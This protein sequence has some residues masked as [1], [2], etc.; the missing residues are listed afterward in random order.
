M[1]PS[2]V[3]SIGRRNLSDYQRYVLALSTKPII[4]E[5]E[6]ARQQDGQGGVLLNP[7]SDEATSNIFTVDARPITSPVEPTT[8]IRTDTAVASPARNR[9]VDNKVTAKVAWA[10]RFRVGSKP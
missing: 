5:R 6:S 9:K 7:N 8:A 1:S 10:W 3:V 4:E 2:L